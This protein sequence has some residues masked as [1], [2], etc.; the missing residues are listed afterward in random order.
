MAFI[1]KIKLL[2][3]D[4]LIIAKVA[5]LNVYNLCDM[6]KTGTP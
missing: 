5:S 2:K 6:A 3:N 4:I 1:L